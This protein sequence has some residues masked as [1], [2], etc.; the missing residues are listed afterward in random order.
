MGFRYLIED[1][2]FEKDFIKNIKNYSIRNKN[3]NKEFVYKKLLDA[4]R[5][6]EIFKNTIDKVINTLKKSD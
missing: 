5:L 6:Q 1:M 3:G 4:V 2:P